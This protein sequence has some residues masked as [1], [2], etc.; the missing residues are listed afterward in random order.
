MSLAATQELEIIWKFI[1]RYINAK[2]A[3]TQMVPG[4]YSR[5]R[6]CFL[7]CEGFYI[8]S[9]DAAFNQRKFN[10]P[11]YIVHHG[12]DGPPCFI[13]TWT[14]VGKLGSDNP[15]TSCA[16]LICDKLTSKIEHLHANGIAL[17]CRTLTSRRSGSRG[18]YYPSSRLKSP[19]PRY[20]SHN[21]L[22]LLD[23]SGY[24]SLLASVQRA[25]GYSGLVFKASILPV[26]FPPLSSI[27]IRRDAR[28][29]EETEPDEATAEVAIIKPRKK[30]RQV[31]TESHP[32]STE[33]N[34][35]FLCSRHNGRR[36]FGEA[37]PL[38][39]LESS[40]V[41]WIPSRSET[42]PLRTLFATIWRFPSFGDS[43]PSK[44]RLLL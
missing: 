32:P 5:Q 43:S 23:E 7:E 39:L 30:Q 41:I 13:L 25:W 33:T 1:L 38:T 9:S 27:E 17:Q 10:G 8:H 24:R 21:D 26:Q 31:S 2:L 19:D 37:F 3:L 16:E 34:R 28:F 35:F 44:A 6:Y 22:Q 14:N 18:S 29:F 20:R 12:L 40:H 36:L 11:C 15:F 4:S 42:S